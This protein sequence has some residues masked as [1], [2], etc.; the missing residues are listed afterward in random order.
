MSR[1]VIHTLPLLLALTLLGGFGPRRGKSD[2]EAQATWAE[3]QREEARGDL[4]GAARRLQQ[5]L[6]DYPESPVTPA[7]AALL[8]EIQLQKGQL[9]EALITCE[10]ALRPDNPADV[11]LSG[12]FTA[13]RVYFKQGRT[14][15]ARAHLAPLKGKLSDA[16]DQLELA[17]I[18]VE[19]EADSGNRV[20]YLE[21][22]VLLAELAP[23]E[24]DTLDTQISSEIEALSDDELE[25]ATHT[26]GNR[27]PGDEIQLELIHR[28]LRARDFSGAAVRC[29][30]FLASFPH[31]GATSQVQLLK[32]RALHQDVVNPSRIGVVLPLTGR[33]AAQGEQVRAGLSLA[34]KALPAPRWATGG[35]ELVIKDSQGDEDVA[36]A[37]VRSLVLEDHVVAIIGPLVTAETEKAARAAEALEVPILVLSQKPGMPEVGP[38]VFRAFPTTDMQME[39]LAAWVYDGLAITKV[40]ILYPEERYGASMVD[41][42]W[43]AF[44]AKGGQVTAVED[45]PSNAESFNTTAQRL[46][47][48]AWP[49]LRTADIRAVE[50]RRADAGNKSDDAVVA[51]P[52]VDFGAL[53]IADDHKTAALVASALAIN[54]FP[55]GT[56][57][58]G[59]KHPPIKLLGLNTWNNKDLPRIGGEYFVGSAFV[60]HFFVDSPDPESAAFV[61]TWRTYNNREPDLFAASGYDALGLTLQALSTSTTPPGRVEA[62]RALANTRDYQGATGSLSFD[63]VGELEVPMYVLSINRKRQIVQVYPELAPSPATP[64][65]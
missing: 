35:I 5:L 15:D 58:A 57:T 1:L 6:R 28:Q 9:N 44:E 30:S 41:T 65:P 23:E 3:A 47:I 4:D 20:E 38:F 60:T 18:M 56:F 52:L 53:L 46:G 59:S 17:R 25:R 54:E 64:A 10:R 21:W 34:V 7:G 36:E 51:P 50:R 43:T 24:R 31:H 62:Q 48:Q 19:I 12:H 22:L 26:F 40:G 63:P 29:D 11:L 8:A 37:A 42:F 33:F 14:S 39:Q 32:E 45:Y 55:L 16:A 61:K 49:H 13:G 27:P 2:A